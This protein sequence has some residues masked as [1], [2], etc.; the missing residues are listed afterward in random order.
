MNLLE[1][2]HG[3]VAES[4][5]GHG[6]LLGLLDDMVACLGMLVYCKLSCLG[7]VKRKSAFFDRFSF[8]ASSPPPTRL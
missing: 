2:A 7:A 8:S 4:H 1:G 5:A 6:G 3:R